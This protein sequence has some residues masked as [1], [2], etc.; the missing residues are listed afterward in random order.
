LAAATICIA[1]VIFCVA[2]TLEIRLRISFKLG[3]AD[4]VPPLSREGGNN[5]VQRFLQDRFQ[6]RR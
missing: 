6:F 2:F 3:M 5:E 1:L 4:Q